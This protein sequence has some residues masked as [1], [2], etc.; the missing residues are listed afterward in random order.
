MW[1]MYKQKKLRGIFSSTFLITN[2]RYPAKG[3][4]DCYYH[5]LKMFNCFKLLLFLGSN[6]CTYIIFIIVPCSICS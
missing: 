6:T 1:C 3:K 5:C 2:L 4:T